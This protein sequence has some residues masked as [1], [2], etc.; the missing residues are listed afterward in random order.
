MRRNGPELQRV[1]VDTARD[2]EGYY[3][4]MDGGEYIGPFATEDDRDA[5][6]GAALRRIRR[7]AEE[8]GHRLRPG[9][10]GSWVIEPAEQ[11]A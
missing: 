1:V 4:S 9:S 7:A 8:A 11:A 2:D 6:I 10:G 3:F 5:E